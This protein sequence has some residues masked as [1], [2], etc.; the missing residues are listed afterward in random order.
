[1]KYIVT[2]REDTGKEEIF[3]FCTSINHDCMAEAISEIRSSTKG[4]WKK[5][6]R[7]PISAGFVKNN[8]CYGES[9]S[10]GLKSRREDND[11]LYNYE[12]F[13]TYG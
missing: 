1:M 6:R 5:V 8:I 3:L 13:N 11:L 12:H 7:E 4:N 10:L 2:K 9:I